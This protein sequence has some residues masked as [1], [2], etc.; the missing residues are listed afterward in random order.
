MK[1]NLKL[2]LL[3]VS[4]FLAFSNQ[5][6]A[7]DVIQGDGNVKCVLPNGNVIVGNNNE[8]DLVNPINDPAL[9]FGNGN[10]WGGS[11]QNV[12]NTYIFGTGNKVTDGGMTLGNYV[13][14]SAGGIAIGIGGAQKGAVSTGGLA[15]MSGEKEA[16]NG[17]LLIGSLNS[18]FMHSTQDGIKMSSTSSYYNIV[19]PILGSV[20]INTRA[21]FNLSGMF[22]Y[23]DNPNYAPGNGENKRTTWSTMKFDNP[24]IIQNVLNGTADTDAVNVKQLNTA[25]AGV[26]SG[27]NPL[28]VL[29]DDST[30][31]SISFNNT[32]LNNIA[33]G[34]YDTDAA[35]WGQTKTAI[36]TSLNSAKSY[37]DN[38]ISNIN[39]GSGGITQAQLDAAITSANTYSSTLA[40]SA[41]SS[42]NIYSNNKAVTTLSSANQYTRDEIAKIPSSP[43]GV[44]KA[45]V[46]NSV[47]SAI[48]ISKTYTNDEIAKIQPG[49]SG[50]V[51]KG[52][53]DTQDTF[54]LKTANGY[55]DARATQ[56]LNSAKSY[57]D[58]KTNQAIKESKDYTDVVATN[59]L[60][61][62]N[63]YTDNKKV[64]AV[65]ESIVYTNAKADETLANAN[66]F[67]ES[68]KV[69]A[70][71]ESKDYTN[72]KA[73]ETLSNAN[74]YTDNRISELNFA[75]KDYVNNSVNSGVKKANDYTDNKFEQS[76]KY[77]YSAGAMA[78]AAAGIVVDP[79][80]DRQVGA[81]IATVH[82]QSALAVGIA[83][84]TG[85][86][87]Y[88]NAR[89]SVA[90]GMTGLSVGVMKGF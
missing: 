24:T 64:E 15:I 28:S 89:V 4:V 48:N 40:N 18:G 21:G 37:T 30:K 36:A 10:Q 82:G 81:S 62:A 39:V 54:I 58:V 53:V 7:V 79:R 32:K 35:A 67:S 13:Q 29:F 84:K 19:D 63:T 59:T 83:W 6:Y 23:I 76:K 56:T 90:N 71:S 52:Y 72:S 74:T 78:M 47:N 55:T 17:E 20:G 42:A 85:R 51:D 43:G 45:Y 88:A 2:N 14:A 70:V 65:N 69:E 8:C 27:G 25:I 31:A 61:N 22:N 34:V 12:I 1:R 44:D 33:N 57:T 16:R 60:N 73:N 87:G 68:K 41:L 26:S 38:A 3:A 5:A 50:G 80:L 86:N 11:T 66:K 77:A 49:G 9:I 46:D 75:D